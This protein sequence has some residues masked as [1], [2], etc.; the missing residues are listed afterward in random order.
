MAGARRALRTASWLSVCVLLASAASAQTGT[1]SSKLV[2]DQAASDLATAQ[3]LSFKYYADGATT[4]TALAGVTCA[5]TASPFVCQV[6]YPAFTPGS[7]TLQL[8][9]T[10]AAGESAK[11]A[12]FSFS[13]VVIPA[14]PANLRIQ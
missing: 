5:G 11:S 7:H 3:A 13:F 8:T 1:P 14:A 2:W 9:A 10:N 4:G 12:T 6:N